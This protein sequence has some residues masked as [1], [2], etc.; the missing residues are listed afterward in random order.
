M[1][2]PLPAH[3]IPGPSAQCRPCLACVSGPAALNGPQT[4]QESVAGSKGSY[5][6]GQSLLQAQVKSYVLVEV[7]LPNPGASPASQC[8]VFALW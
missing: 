6:S 1:A 3:K 7:S 4:A 8:I 2:L 5:E